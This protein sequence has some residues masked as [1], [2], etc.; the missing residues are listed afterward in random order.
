MRSIPS[1]M[2]VAIA[3]LLAPVTATV[4]A[5][6]AVA[7]ATQFKVGDTVYV[8]GCGESCDCNTIQTS[9][10]KCHCG[11]ALVEGKVTKVAAGKVTV[12]TAKGERVIKLT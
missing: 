11:M 2:L 9:P 1:A 12:K 8:C 6:T 4:A 7:A 3:L 5:E 10:G